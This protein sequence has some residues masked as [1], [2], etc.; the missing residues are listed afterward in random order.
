MKKWI[1]CS[2]PIFA[3]AT[4]NPQLN[5][6]FGIFV[7]VFQNNEGSIPNVHV[8]HDKSRNKRRCSIIRLDKPEYSTHHKYNP[9]MPKDVKEKFLKIM[10]QP[11]P[12]HIIQLSDGSYRPATGYE[13]AVKIWEDTFEKGSLAKFNLD[14][15]GDIINI[16]YSNI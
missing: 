11:W 6:E 16:D 2:Q 5:T 14:K 1:K 12:S 9:A 15:N 4:I 10:T 8:Y 13:A 7:E 3:M